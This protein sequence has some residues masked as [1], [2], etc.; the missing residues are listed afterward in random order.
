[1]RPSAARMVSKRPKDSK[2]NSGGSRS[3][4][5]EGTIR[6]SGVSKSS[7]ACVEAAIRLANDYYGSAAHRLAA[8]T[9]SRG[10]I[11]S[12]KARQ[13]DPGTRSPATV[14]VNGRTGCATWKSCWTTP[15]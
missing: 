7:A 4:P 15:T 12:L 6:I 11:D 8:P 9:V 10:L 13:L 1:M 3:N 14:F 2:G 5:D